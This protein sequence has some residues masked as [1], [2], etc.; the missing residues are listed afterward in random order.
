[1]SKG[2][3]TIAQNTVDCDYL[4]LA[5]LQAMSVK[6]TMPAAKYA[7]V[8][9]AATNKEVTA[10]HRRVFDH[11]ILIENDL[12][13]T[14]DWKLAN[15]WQ[16]GKLTPFKETIKVES[17]ILFTRSIEHWWHTFRL[18]DV[19]MSTGCRNF[20]QEVALSRQYRRVFDANQLPDVYTG[21]MYFRYTR[22]STE[23][24][25][26]AEQL[27]ANWAAVSQLLVQC[28]A[29]PTTDV[30]YALAA[31]LIGVER[32]TLPIEFINFVHM[33]PAVN[34]WPDQPW[35]E[36][37]MHEL[38]LPMLRIANVN[39]YHPVHYHVKSWATD[40]IIGEYERELF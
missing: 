29:I 12:A 18:R 24:F 30:V 9:D 10:Q 35:P 2:F 7:V 1:M 31:R 32:C 27:F 37:A 4:R 15:E 34:G 23:F 11:V 5:Y 8:V 22:T 25:R 39:Q 38:D 40:H 6:L 19:V 21:L 26:L 17:D 16:V 13:A 14:D 36:I 3:L 28:D 33:K 20:K